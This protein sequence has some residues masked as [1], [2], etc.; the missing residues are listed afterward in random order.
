MCY[1]MAA[2]PCGRIGLSSKRRGS[3]TGSIGQ[4]HARPRLTRCVDGPASLSARQRPRGK[5]AGPNQEPRG[6]PAAQINYAQN[7][8]G[9]VADKGQGDAWTGGIR[10]D[11]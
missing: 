4:E 5:R 3:A 6:A 11:A 9:A 8:T 10:D 7:T 1:E 2:P